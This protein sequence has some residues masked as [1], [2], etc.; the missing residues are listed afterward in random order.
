M[1]YSFKYLFGYHQHSLNTE[2]QRYFLLCSAEK[3]SHTGLEQLEGKWWQNLHFWVNC[4]FKIIVTKQCQC[5][6]SQNKYA[7]KG[8]SC[9]CSKTFGPNVCF[10]AWGSSSVSFCLLL[11]PSLNYS[12][13]NVTGPG[14]GTRKQIKNTWIIRRN[15]STRKLQCLSAGAAW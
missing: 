4:S 11:S 5:Q 2:Y 15:K 13:A 12:T 1:N 7:V 3:E 14:R 6:C 8:L 10:G 9:W